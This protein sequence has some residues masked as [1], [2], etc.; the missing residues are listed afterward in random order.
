MVLA[1]EEAV[2]SKKTNSSAP[3][4]SYAAPTAT[5]SPA[6]LKSTKLTPFT[7]L[8]LCTSKQGIILFVNIIFPPF[9]ALK[10]SLKS[11]NQPLHSSLGETDK[12]KYYPFL[13]K[14]ELKYYILSLLRH[15]PDFLPLNNKNVQNKHTALFLFHEIT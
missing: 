5:G 11:S 13:W 10:N 3:A 4:L 2:I 14:H 1:S 6:S 7:T 15:P 9:L 8:P 12:Q